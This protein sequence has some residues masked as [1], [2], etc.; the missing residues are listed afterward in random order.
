MTELLYE[1]EGGKMVPS[2]KDSGGGP[3]IGANTIDM[4]IQLVADER[5]PSYLIP[6][7]TCD[8]SSIPISASK[9]KVT[10]TGDSLRK[11]TSP[12]ADFKCEITS[13]FLTDKEKSAIT[14]ETYYVDSSNNKLLGTNKIYFDE[15]LL[16]YYNDKTELKK[17]NNPFLATATTADSGVT[18]TFE[19]D[20][21][22]IIT[23]IEA[24]ES[25]VLIQ[26]MF[27][28]VNSIP[29]TGVTK[30]TLI[31]ISA[32]GF[33]NLKFSGV[34][35]SSPLTFTSKLTLKIET[36]NEPIPGGC[37][38]TKLFGSDI[39]T[40]HLHKVLELSEYQDFD[41][42]TMA[43][44]P[45]SQPATPPDVDSAAVDLKKAD[46]AYK[47]A[48]AAA[49]AAETEATK[50]KT[51]AKVEIDKYVGDIKTKMDAISPDDKA[52]IPPV[53]KPFI[54]ASKALATAKD[55][56]DTAAIATAEAVLKSASA[57][58]G[59]KE[60]I[61][62]GLASS[63]LPDS[64]KAVLTDAK[65][66]QDEHVKITTAD[67][68]V[69]KTKAA[70]DAAEAVKVAVAAA[71]KLKTSTGMGTG[72]STTKVVPT[73]TNQAASQ[74]SYTN[75]QQLLQNLMASQQKKLNDVINQLQALQLSQANAGSNAAGL[76]PII[77]RN[78]GESGACGNGDISMESRDGSL[79]FKV[80][81]DK[82][83]GEIGVNTRSAMAQ[84]VLKNKGNQKAAVLNFESTL[85]VD[86]NA[87]AAAAEAAVKPV[88]AAAAAAG[89]VAGNAAGNVAGNAAAGNAAGN[90]AAA[91]PVA[92]IVVTAA[93]LDQVVTDALAK[94][95]TDLTAQQ[96]R[97]TTAGITITL[98]EI[99]ALDSAI[100]EADNAVAAL[101]TLAS[102][103]AN[104]GTKVAALTNAQD[105]IKL[106][107]TAAAAATKAVDAAIAAKQATE[108]QALTDK[109][110]TEATK[111]LDKAKD[112]YKLISPP[113]ATPIDFTAEDELIAT[114]NAAITTATK[115]ADATAKAAAIK[116]A[117]SA[118]DTASTAATNVYAEVKAAAETPPA[119]KVTEL[120][121]AKQ[122][123]LNDAKASL[124]AEETKLT[125]AKGE[126]D[127]INPGP[128]NLDDLTGLH[129]KAIDA[130]A[131]AKTALGEVDN[132][133]NAIKS[134]GDD[135]E[136]IKTAV[137]A[138]VTEVDKAVVAV[139]TAVE[140]VK[141]AVDAIDAAKPLTYD[142][143]TKAYKAYTDKKGEYDAAAKQVSG[144]SSQAGG[145]TPL[146]EINT[147]KSVLNKVVEDIKTRIPVKTDKLSSED[148]DKLKD[149][150]EKQKKITELTEA[151][152]LYTKAIEGI[153]SAS[154]TYTNTKSD[155]IKAA[156]LKLDTLISNNNQNKKELLEDQA[157]L[158][159]SGPQLQGNALLEVEKR[160][161]AFTLLTEESKLKIDEAQQ[162]YNDAVKENDSQGGGSKPRSK[163]SSK[164]KSSSS[165]SKNKT[166]KNHHSAQKSSKSKTPKII[167]NE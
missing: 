124:T 88:A 97:L 158:T 23:A 62:A 9:V 119:T 21:N 122:T 138:A 166:K 75:L 110:K 98:P 45:A 140:A 167:M 31:Q 72:A 51:A 134:V 85:V 69:V 4:K 73:A 127:K 12:P 1:Q 91:A 128:A 133:V 126:L 32:G 15:S 8:D 14:I 67:A 18:Y 81:Y 160:I 100:K 55:G 44:K 118:V 61:D 42:L 147:A 82:I 11:E 154:S 129:Q 29:P 106:A 111:V 114:A 38:L 145:D 96:N 70:V 130:I 93:T 136:K 5:L 104:D 48:T 141:T 77:V 107:T 68:E 89:N 101:A 84:S 109:L 20:F 117:T 132:L 57:D 112:D 66:I 39:L 94:A 80:P 116:I 90:V 103:D 113:P 165:K 25:Y 79:I 125:A 41:F 148:F 50:V 13:N 137:T 102:T 74:P 17:S 161:Q 150:D 34:P 60:A 56:K 58:P 53:V 86:P 40:G 76:P 159:G 120:S 78:P 37:A 22:T 83:L 155:V 64:V 152:E 3:K 164:S 52:K 139:T 43:Q 135:A 59:L 19:F 16:S 26:N 146:E 151:T 143:Y 36:T 149:D 7:L 142:K 6:N 162:E 54:D 47:A 49:K 99:T 24:L 65:I 157:K 105:K 153:K 123:E 27:K 144:M 131:L 121:A 35:F 10:L 33:L 30:T 2:P 108:I 95:K 156:K 28:F 46:E 63:S 115:E 87:A 92:P 71:A 163:S